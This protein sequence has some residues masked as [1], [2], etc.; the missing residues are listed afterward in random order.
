MSEDKFNELLLKIRKGATASVTV[1]Q[2]VE[3]LTRLGN[4]WKVEKTVAFVTTRGYESKDR[5]PEA[6]YQYDLSGIQET[7]ARMKALEV[8]R[9]PASPK[10][11]QKY[12]MDLSEVKVGQPGSWFFTYYEFVGTEGWLF[13]SPEGQLFELG[14]DLSKVQRGDYKSMSPHPLAKWLETTKLKEQVSNY[15]GLDTHEAEREKKKPKTRG[16]S[17]TCPCCFRNIKLKSRNDAAPTIVLHGYLR[18]G[19]GQVQ[20]SCYG[21]GYQ[22]FELSS[23]G[24]EHLVGVLNDREA[25]QKDFLR[26][27]KGGEVQQLSHQLSRTKVIIVKPGEVAWERLLKERIDET[28]RILV[29][30]VKDLQVLRKLIADWKAQPLPEEGQAIKPPPTQFR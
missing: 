16:G 15:L 3:V 1:K 17:G 19:W 8:S 25:H 22:P 9:K 14:A 12:L 11:G 26:R 18:P 2:W 7:H 20:G 10:V 5:R 21:V 23:E 24:T 30:L 6:L 13:T 29:H 27:L 4:G 28:E